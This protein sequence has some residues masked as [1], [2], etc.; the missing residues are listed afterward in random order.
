[1]VLDAEF[2]IVPP[3]L[4]HGRRS[5]DCLASEQDTVQAKEK[6]FDNNLI[7]VIKV[8]GTLS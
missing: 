1:M 3:A 8:T 4:P 7:T 5:P 6:N 2:C